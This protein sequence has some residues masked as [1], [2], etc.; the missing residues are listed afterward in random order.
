M[1]DIYEENGK[2]FKALSDPNR[3][4]IV[5][6][7]SCGEICACTI[8]EKLDITQPTLS[9]HMKKLEELKLVHVR[10]EGLWS[11]YSL[12]RRKIGAMIS[13]LI[14]ISYDDE[15]CICK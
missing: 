1:N 12:N 11:Y 9:H 2:L 15:K 13:F 8:L 5:E 6:M 7:F 14:K 3:I 10:K 4:K